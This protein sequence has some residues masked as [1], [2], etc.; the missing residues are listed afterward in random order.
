MAGSVA[1]PKGAILGTTYKA[2]AAITK[3]RILKRGAD[4]NT[5][6][7]GTANAAPLGVAMDNQDEVGSA[8]LVAHRAGE[9]VQVESGA[10]V[11][12]DAAVA[13]D[14]TGRAVTATTGQL[15]IGYL[16]EAATAAGELCVLELHRHTA[17]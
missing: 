1:G 10:A 12:L 15:A 17:L 5:A 6:I 9:M 7:L 11:A 4:K 16:R 14:A 13:S 8:V 2:G 3:A